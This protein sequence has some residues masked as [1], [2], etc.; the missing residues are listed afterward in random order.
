MIIECEFKITFPGIPFLF[1]WL[2]LA[3]RLEELP[4]R[5]ASTPF[6]YHLTA[7]SVIS[8]QDLAKILNL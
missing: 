6:C 2:W 5:N 4:E 1:A 3:N 8:T 7:Q